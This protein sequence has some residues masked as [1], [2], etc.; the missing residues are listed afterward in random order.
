MVGSSRTRISFSPIRAATIAVFCFIP[1]DILFRLAVGSSCR[2]SMTLF[3]YLKSVTPRYFACVSR[4]L[5]PRFQ[6]GEGNFT[7]NIADMLP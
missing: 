2:S 6:R 7:G 4:E 3:L 1:L 5:G